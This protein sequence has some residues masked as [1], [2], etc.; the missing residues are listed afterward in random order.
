MFV[1]GHDCVVS[2]IVLLPGPTVGSPQAVSPPSSASW[3][4]SK[5]LPNTE[6]SGALRNLPTVLRNQSHMTHREDTTASAF[7]G[8][9]HTRIHQAHWLS[10]LEPSYHTQE[11]TSQEQT[12]ST[13]GYMGHTDIHATCRHTR[14]STPKALQILTNSPAHTHALE[15]MLESS[16][17]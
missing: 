9:S 13:L 6:V 5:P 1:D 16:T 4:S 3:C 2:F 8:D 12:G 10:P 14:P 11:C 15:H 7:K 17:R